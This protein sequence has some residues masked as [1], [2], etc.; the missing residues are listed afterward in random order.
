M[1]DFII[2]VKKVSL[3]VSLLLSTGYIYSQ[4][5]VRADI[6]LDKKWKTVA[7]DT[8][9]EAYKG[10]ENPGFN[11]SSWSVTDIPHNW[12]RYEGYRRLKHGNR[13][14]F[15][16]YRKEFEISEKYTGKRIFLWFEGV[17]SYAIVWVNE[18]MAGHHAGGRTSFT[19]DITCLVNFDSINVIALRADHPARIRDLPWVCGGCSDEWGFS[20]GSQPM[21][22]FR[23]VHLIVTDQVRIEPFGV[24]LWNDTSVNEQSATINIETEIKNYGNKPRNIINRNYFKDASG[25]CIAETKSAITINPGSP[26]T[27]KPD[28]FLIERPHLWFPDDPYL[29][30]VVSTLIEDGKVI[31]EVVSSYGIRWIR[32]PDVSK[33]EKGRFYLNGNPVFING[34]AEYEHNM[35]KSHAFS[36]EQIRARVMQVKEAGFNAFRDAHQPHNLRYQHYIDSIGL[37]WWPQ[38]AAHIWFDNEAFRQNFKTL[39]ADWIKERRNSPSVILWGLENESSLPEDFAKECSDI[40]RELDPT[41]SGQRKITTCNGGTGTDWNVIQNWSGTYGGDPEAYATEIKRQ[42]L[43]GEYGAWRSI[44]FHMEGPFDQNG[45]WSEDRMTQL[46]EMKVCLAESVSDKCCGQFQ[47]LLSSHEN[48]GRIQNGEGFRDID[49]VGPVNY[50]GLMTVWGEPLDVYYMYRAYHVSADKDPMV[51]IVSHTWPDRWLAPG[52]KDS[53][54]IYS[55][56]DEVELFNDIK[57]MSLGRKVHNGGD[58]RFQWDSVDIRYNILYAAGY[59]NGKAVAEDCI[60]LNHLPEAH[61]F[62]ASGSYDADILTPET[63]FNYL[64]RINCGGPDYQDTFG[65]LWSADRHK[66]VDSTWGSRSWTDEFKGLPPFYGSQRRTFEPVKGTADRKLF[67]SFRYGLDMLQFEFPVP[68]GEYHL[69]LYFAEPWYG[70]GGEADY[71]AWRIFDIAVNDRVVLKNLDIWKEAGYNR[72]LKKT[73]DVNVT[74]GYLKISFPEVISGQA[75]ISAIAVATESQHVIPASG[76]PG[77]TGCLKVFEGN[78]ADKWS[79]QRWL[80]TGDKQYSDNNVT[81]GYLPSYLYG[82]EWIRTPAKLDDKGDTLA[83]FKITKKSDIFIARSA[84]NEKLPSW[85]YGYKPV[86][87]SLFNDLKGGT[88]YRLYSRRLPSGSTVILGAGDENEGMMYTVIIRPVTNIAEPSDQ[89]PARHYRAEDASISGQGIRTGFSDDARYLEIFKPDDNVIEWEIYVGLAGDYALL[90]S[91][92]NSSANNVSA[93]LTILNDEKIIA[94]KKDFEFP[95]TGTSWQTITINSDSQINAGKY[96]LKLTLPGGATL[97]IRE[98][99]VQ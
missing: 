6:L 94:V 24:H 96:T 26:H 31:D 89:R 18:K 59:V 92:M 76:S 2:S 54:I 21:G 14:G 74:G 69:E 25:K 43:N 93:C 22:I 46:L 63:G 11:D 56:C 68:D 32:W 3:C 78:R 91:Y 7:C 57:S 65:N 67:Q 55:N 36:A 15:A 17:G 64:Y 5:T 60:L 86:E 41:A 95:G 45:S 98:L 1:N 84:T 39:L 82:C 71:A 42:L 23:P 62:A 38:F 16:W 75:I 20:E 66:S 28:S 35:G 13:H 29:Y 4:I 90:I 40:I 77:V 19:L 10:F 9:K 49:R 37:L 72:A 85:M 50:K 51:Y 33:N 99:T 88:G 27:I 34:T 8:N 12:D 80:D 58:S 52:I 73:I 53:I 30:Q 47:W 83:T 44:D 87:A 48:P 97:K 81:F 61:D 70:R 79:V